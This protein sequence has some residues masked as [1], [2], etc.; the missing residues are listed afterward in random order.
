MFV[1]ELIEIESVPIHGLS[2]TFTDLFHRLV[3]ALPRVVRRI[4]GISSSL[5]AALSR[6][7]PFD[8]LLL[9]AC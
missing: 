4:A 7:D 1:Y 3:R 2:H 9:L 6:D 5:R 8:E